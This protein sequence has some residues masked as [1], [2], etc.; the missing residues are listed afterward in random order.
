MKYYLRMT[1]S[2]I[3]LEPCSLCGAKGYGV[4]QPPGKPPTFFCKFH[5]EQQWPDKIR[6][7][8][9]FG[10]VYF[11]HTEAQEIEYAKRC[12]RYGAWQPRPRGTFI[13]AWWRVPAKLLKSEGRG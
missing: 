6:L 9:E 12:A 3:K 5:T 8:N 1:P 4:H 10:L 13:A 2:V 11:G 7:V